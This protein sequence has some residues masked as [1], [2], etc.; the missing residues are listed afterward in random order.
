MDVLL[1]QLIR[2][3]PRDTVVAGGHR[4]PLRV[5]HPGRGDGQRRG[6]LDRGPP[7]LHGRFPC[8]V[9]HPPV[10]RQ[11]ADASRDP[12]AHRVRAA[13]LQGAGGTGLPM[14]ADIPQDTGVPGDA[15]GRR[16]ATQQR[17]DAGHTSCAQRSSYRR[18]NLC[19]RRHSRLGSM[20]HES[21]RRRRRLAGAGR[22]R[23]RIRNPQDPPGGVCDLAAKRAP[24][25]RPGSRRDRR[26][27]RRAG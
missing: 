19:R 24:H 16:A 6:D 17:P 13:D 18:H 27:S 23:P 12:L 1:A 3:P 15:Q 11:A 10:G 9:L 2:V 21:D 25:S 4:H 26:Y 22:C 7:D 8:H 5:H 20:A 14:V